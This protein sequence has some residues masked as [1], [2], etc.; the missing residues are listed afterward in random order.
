MGIWEPPCNSFSFLISSIS[1]EYLHFCLITSPGILY[2]C[3][4]IIVAIGGEIDTKLLLHISI[5][6]E[7]YIISLIRLIAFFLS[8]FFV[9]SSNLIMCMLSFTMPAGTNSNSEFLLIFLSSSE[10]GLVFSLYL[11]FYYMHI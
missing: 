1:T 7:T 8:F 6:S 5:P 3:Y 4:R 11:L 10:G 9:L 2:Y